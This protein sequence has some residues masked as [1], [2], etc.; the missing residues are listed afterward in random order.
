LPISPLLFAPILFRP[1]PPFLESGSYQCTKTCPD[2]DGNQSWDKPNSL[3]NLV[4]DTYRRPSSLNTSAADIATAPKDYSEGGDE[5][6]ESYGCYDAGRLEIGAMRSYR[7]ANTKRED[8]HTKV[9]DVFHNRF[10]SI[11]L[12]SDSPS[13]V[14]A[15][16]DSVDEAGRER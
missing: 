14:M 9:E 10:L 1:L 2:D 8:H 7:V 5:D 13:T 15:R 11:G 3:G 6:N 16:R 4:E 12:L